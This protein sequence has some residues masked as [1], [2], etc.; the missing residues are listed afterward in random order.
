VQVEIYRDG[1][2]KAAV[3]R[4]RWAKYQPS[5][6]YKKDQ[7]REIFSFWYDS[8]VAAESAVFEALVMNTKKEVAA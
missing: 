8:E 4:S 2:V 7:W 1:T 5:V 6:S 3:L